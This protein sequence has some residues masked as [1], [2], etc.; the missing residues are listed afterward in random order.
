MLEDIIEIDE[1]IEQCKE[2]LEDNTYFLQTIELTKEEVNVLINEIERL[3]NDYLEM[4][5]NFRNAND[6]IERLKEE[7][8]ILQNAS[9]EVEEEKDKEI[10]R[11]N[12]IIKE[13]RECI[14]HY[15]IENEDYSKIYNDEEKELLEI[16]D[17]VDK[18]NIWI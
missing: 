14:N 10:E 16:L 5:D 12:S 1:I 9:D 13:V 6:E 11:L 15:A 17:K 18:E 8:M 4:K 3:N 7:Y 2:L